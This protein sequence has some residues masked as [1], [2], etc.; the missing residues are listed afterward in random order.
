MLLFYRSKRVTEISQN[1][2][3]LLLLSLKIFA[4]FNI[5]FKDT[6]SLLS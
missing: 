4:F 1:D 3:V 5:F 2:N 6:V